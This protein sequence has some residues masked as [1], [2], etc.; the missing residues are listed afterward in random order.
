MGDDQARDLPPPRPIG[1]LTR[2]QMRT[3]LFAYIE[4]F[5]NRQRHEARLDHRTPNEAYTACSPA[6]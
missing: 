6:A 2:S 4:T 3:I 5:D 1:D